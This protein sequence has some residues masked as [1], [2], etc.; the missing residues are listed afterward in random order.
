MKKQNQTD[1][2]NEKIRL[3]QMKQER[4]FILLKEQAHVAYE[5]LKP[6]NLI[7]S[8]FHE[9]ASSPDIKNNIVSNVIGFVTGFLSR[10]VLMGSSDNPIKR[11]L[12]TVLQF[13]IANVVSKHSDT[14]KSVGGKLLLRILK[15]KK[16]PE[17]E[18]S[19]NG[20]GQHNEVK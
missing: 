7:K 3:L 10:K 18:F 17:P 16:E 11:I 20:N 19:S 1:A 5:S 15:Y 4:E 9:V 13:G 2:L 6:I 8:T 14:I 12:G